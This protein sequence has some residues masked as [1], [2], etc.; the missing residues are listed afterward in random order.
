[1]I[2]W[3]FFFLCFVL[4]L[5]I[6]CIFCRKIGIGNTLSWEDWML[7]EPNFQEEGK[8]YGSTLSNWIYDLISKNNSFWLL[9]QQLLGLC[10]LRG[11]KAVRVL[12]VYFRKMN[13][14]FPGKWNGKG[15]ENGRKAAQPPALSW[16]KPPWDVWSKTRSW[17][18]SCSEHSWRDLFSSTD[19]T[20]S[21]KNLNSKKHIVK[22][23]LKAHPFTRSSL[24]EAVWLNFNQ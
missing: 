11:W 7:I 12:E 20:Q 1:M 4:F 15:K 3:F 18:I 6:S 9:R 22:I 14:L 23:P 8:R 21:L 5:L 16:K 19:Y 24:V 2:S 13:I 17:P 10:L